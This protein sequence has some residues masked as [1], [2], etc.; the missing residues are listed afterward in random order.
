MT[1][2][3][4]EWIEAPVVPGLEQQLNIFKGGCDPPE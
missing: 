2:K 4:V 1:K 3:S